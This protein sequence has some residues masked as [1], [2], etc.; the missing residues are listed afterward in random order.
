MQPSPSRPEDWFTLYYPRL[1]VAYN[2]IPKNACSTVKASLARANDGATFVVSPHELDHHYRT[3]PARLDG[4]KTILVLRDPL[5]RFISAYL[6]KVAR[7]IEDSVREMVA[8]IFYELGRPPPVGEESVNIAEFFDWIGQQPHEL[9]DA[10]WRPQAEL[11]RF[12]EYDHILHVETLA[13]DWRECGL[14]EVAPLVDWTE[15]ATASPGPDPA[16]AGT[17][18]IGIPGHFI[19]GY[20]ITTGRFP[21]KSC[22]TIDT[23][24]AQRVREFYQFD[25]ALLDQVRSA[26]RLARANLQ[27][28]AQ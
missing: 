23:E 5:A 8:Q 17:N 12:S 27:T 3:P 1:K 20:R 28:W 16:L 19:Y 2:L 25:Y 9:L 13:Q 21:P 18:L 26:G 24:F 11:L 22:F 7:P 15:H 14:S 10:H 6:D 4:W